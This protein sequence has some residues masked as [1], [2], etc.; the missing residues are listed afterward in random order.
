MKLSKINAIFSLICTLL[1]MIHSISL[2]LWMLSFGSI[3][4]APSSIPR[5]LTVFFVI[6]AIISIIKMIS[7]NKGKQKNKY[8]S[9]VKL[10]TPT[11][12]QRVSG[13]LLIIFTWLHIAGTIGIMQPPQVVHAI[14]P[15]LFFTLVLTHVAI[16]TSKAFITL[17]IGNAAFIKKFDIIIKILCAIT[18]IADIVG[19]YLFVC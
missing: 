18:L 16:S 12:I 4:Q 1:I 13:I 9:Y 11:I 8:N 7:V 5:G 3:P 17:G 10:N 2:A 15:P 6:H 19:F 14:V